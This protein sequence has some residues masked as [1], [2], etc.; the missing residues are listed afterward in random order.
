VGRDRRPVDGVGLGAGGRT[1]ARRDDR[2]SRRGDRR[3][4]RGG[5]GADG[6]PSPSWGTPPPGG[7]PAGQPWSP[8]K[9]GNAGIVVGVVLIG[10]G[11]WFLIDQYVHIDWDLLWPV[12]IMVLGGALIAG[13]VMRGRPG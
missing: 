11:I 13:A 4:R 2:L 7:W 8:P 10:L 3:A 1:G 6:S 12:V 5:V 9:P